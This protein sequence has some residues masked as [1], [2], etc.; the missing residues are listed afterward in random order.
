MNTAT[1]MLL[2]KIKNQQEINLNSELEKRLTGPSKQVSNDIAYILAMSGTSSASR[3]L[4]NY[5]YL[6]EAIIDNVGYLSNEFED[7]LIEWIKTGDLKKSKCAIELLVSKLSS[8]RLAQLLAML[9]NLSREKADHFARII[10]A[11]SRVLDSQSVS[12]SLIISAV[13]EEEKLN[14]DTGHS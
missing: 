13:F 2:R 3:L 10:T 1:I 7:L 8:Q 5:P 11:F 4:E 9:P 12:F 14:A 6:W